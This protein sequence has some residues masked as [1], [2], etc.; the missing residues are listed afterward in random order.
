[1]AVYEVE[2]PD[3]TIYEVEGP[4]NAQDGQVIG[5]LRQHLQGQKLQGLQA[6]TERLRALEQ[7]VPAP[8]P[9]TSLFGYA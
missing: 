1:M 7:Q 2:G 6:E 5:A 9:E 3:G 8:V 4:D